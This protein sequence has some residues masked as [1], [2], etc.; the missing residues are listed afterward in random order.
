MPLQLVVHS[1]NIDHTTVIQIEYASLKDDEYQLWLRN[2]LTFYG[3]E[4]LSIA[5]GY[6]DI[7]SYE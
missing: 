5:L 3:A 7:D 6:K 1:E 2:R 4:N